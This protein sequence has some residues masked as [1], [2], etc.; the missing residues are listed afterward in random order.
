MFTPAT[1]TTTSPTLS[2]NAGSGT[3]PIGYIVEV[4]VA[5]TLATGQQLYRPSGFYS[6]A[7]TSFTPFSLS[8]GNTYVFVITTVV[9]AGANM[10]TSPHRS[11]L[12]GGSASVISAPITVGAG[13]APRLVRGDARVVK[14]F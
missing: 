4:F 14:R 6:T 8:G 5:T 12:P 9:N 7:K 3:T 2:W 1:L 10:E 11:A 13:A